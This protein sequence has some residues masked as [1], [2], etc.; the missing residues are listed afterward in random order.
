MEREEIK[1][2][3]Y[4]VVAQILKIDSA[5]I[6]EDHLFTADLGAEF[7]LVRGSNHNFYS[8]PWKAELVETTL[9]WLGPSEEAQDG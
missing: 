5:G 3:V 1:K 6:Q 7:H 2:R 8:I 9:R 4:S